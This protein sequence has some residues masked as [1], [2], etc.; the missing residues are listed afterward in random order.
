M[1]LRAAATLGLLLGIWLV[2]SSCGENRTSAAGNATGGVTTIAD[3]KPRPK[4]V[5]HRS[6]QSQLGS[7]VEAMAALRRGLARGLNYGEY[8]HEVQ[9]ARRVYHGVR[10][11]R[12]SVACLLSSGSHAEHALNLYI[13][14]A[15]SWG[16]CLS[17]AGC[18]T[19]SVEP[20]LQRSWALASEQLSKA[21]RASRD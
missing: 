8:L 21:Q 17:T 7:F 1:R 4:P 10:P 9:S 5:L 2:F 14:A 20:K 6:C 13:D 11:D 3:T 18:S 16:D 19:T 15:N 12:L